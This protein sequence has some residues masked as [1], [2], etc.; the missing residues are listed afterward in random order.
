[1][2][3]KVWIVAMALS[4]A[5]LSAWLGLGLGLGVLSPRTV[6]GAFSRPPKASLYHKYRVCVPPSC[7]WRPLQRPEVPRSS[8]VVSLVADSVMSLNL[9]LFVPIPS[10]CPFASSVLSLGRLM[11]LFPKKSLRVLVK[12]LSKEHRC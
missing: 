6:P 9:N 1:M 10:Q 5:T 3:A 12:R 11:S 4:S 7:S 2:A 8:F